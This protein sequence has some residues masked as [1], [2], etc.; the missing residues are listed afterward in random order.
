MTMKKG[1]SDS[2]VAR[3]LSL[4]PNDHRSIR[5]HNP[6]PLECTSPGPRRDVL[7]VDHKYVI[8]AR[9]NVLN[10]GKWVICSLSARRVKIELRV[11]VG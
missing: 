8:N 10:A 11:L 5:I 6:E 1:R 3:A 2:W 9:E 7:P 4:A